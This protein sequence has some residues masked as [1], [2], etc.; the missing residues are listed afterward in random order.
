VREFLCRFSVLRF[1]KFWIE[2]GMF[3]LK[4]LEER[5]IVTSWEDRAEGISPENEFLLR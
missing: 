1:V 4:E 5:S 2:V 3:P